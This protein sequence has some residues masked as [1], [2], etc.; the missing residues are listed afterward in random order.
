MRHADP[1]VLEIPQHV[2]AITAKDPQEQIRPGDVVETVIVPRF[3]DAVPETHDGGVAELQGEGGLVV[4]QRAEREFGESG[5]LEG[6]L[7]VEG[8]D[9]VGIAGCVGV[10]GRGVGEAKEVLLVGRDGRQ[11]EH[12]V[13]A[14]LVVG[15]KDFSVVVVGIEEVEVVGD[16]G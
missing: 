13:D 9:V 15:A 14:D 1:P 16:D 6:G 3:L 10:V 7:I 5:G 4:G 2:P 12:V 8:D 11:V